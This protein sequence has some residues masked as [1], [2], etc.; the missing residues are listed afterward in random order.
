M[1][2]F[3][4]QALL[5][6]VL[7]A[8]DRAP[9]N[10]N[11]LSAITGSMSLSG[12]M[13]FA[14]PFG[15]VTGPANQGNTTY[16]NSAS[17]SITGTTSPV[18]TL[19]TLN[20]QGFMM[21][22]IQP[23]STTYILSKWDTY[24]HEFL[25]H[26]FVKSIRFPEEEDAKPGCGKGEDK[27]PHIECEKRRTHRNDP[28]SQ[29]YAEFSHLIDAMVSKE[30]DGGNVDMRSLMILDPLGTPV[31]IGQ[32]IAATTPI[33]STAPTT[34]PT[35]SPSVSSMSSLVRSSVGAQFPPHAGSYFVRLTYVMKSGEE[36]APSDAEHID[37]DSKSHLLVLAPRN[38][39]S[40]YLGYNVY[41]GTSAGAEKRQNDKPIKF[42]KDWEEPAG[43]LQNFGDLPSMATTQYPINPYLPKST[44]FVQ[45]TYV[46]SNGTETV[47]S[48]DAIQ[49]VPPGQVL[50]VS[51]GA[52]PAGVTWYNVY[53]GKSKDVVS[54][55][56]R[57]PV[58]A[59]THWTMDNRGLK[60]GSPPPQPPGTS[61]LVSS[62]YNVF[63]TIN[64]LADGQ[65]HVGNAPCPKYVRSGVRSDPNDLCASNSKGAFAQFYK[66]YAGQVVLCLDTKGD[67]E[68]FHGHV[69]APISDD[70]KEARDAL[71]DS[72][73]FDRQIDGSIVI[74]SFQ[75]VFM[76]KPPGGG[77]GT[78][79]AAGGGGSGG[80]GGGA[81]GAGGGGGGNSG[82]TSG[83]MPQVTLAL[84]PN[85]ISAILHSATCK[86]DQIVLPTETEEHFH[87]ESRQ[88]THIEWR[89]IAEVIQYLGAAARVQNPDSKT[90]LRF[91]S[92]DD[93]SKTI[94]YMFTYDEGSA[95]IGAAQRTHWYRKDFR[96]FGRTAAGD[97]TPLTAPGVRKHSIGN[98]DA[99]ASSRLR[100]RYP[101]IFEAARS[102][103]D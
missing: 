44:Y 25:L 32:T 50:D 65:L 36:T 49:T 27:T 34:L 19:G 40:Q 3:A 71:A 21:T 14:V 95:S 64:G 69:I 88:F 5:A 99:N 78:T 1:D 45:I 10:F 100:G 91:G 7:R 13:G 20:T 38:I 103:V 6:N 73:A 58:L 90:F 35:A 53:V 18:I 61:Y 43:N 26:L 24:S 83:A 59:A 96:R 67:D 85:R 2:D 80:G 63:S 82:G 8:R 76:A 22:M 54:R 41:V 89:S 4:D 70:E 23:I 28:D 101:A 84:Q 98:K 39:F 55:Q 74:Q 66:E 42:G 60:S 62:D 12:T 17:P 37:I 48:P 15:P 46:T 87:R 30:D 9:L 51:I 57:D 86:T 11:D 29:D 75:S 92:D 97:R 77:G 68:Q 33:P 102:R 31:P 52:A 79:P 81:S 72:A 94:E 93:T 16:K 56:N 47:S